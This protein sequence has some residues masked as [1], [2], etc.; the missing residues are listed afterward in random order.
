VHSICIG[1]A[2]I[3]VG[4]RKEYRRSVTLKPQSFAGE[5]FF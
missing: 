5:G 2:Y 3:D 4:T 1:K